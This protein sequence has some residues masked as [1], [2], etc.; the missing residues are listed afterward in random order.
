VRKTGL[1]RG[2]G[3]ELDRGDRENLTTIYITHGHA[4]HVFG[5]TT[6]LG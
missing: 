4:D 1:E 6:I 2:A 5:L 3:R